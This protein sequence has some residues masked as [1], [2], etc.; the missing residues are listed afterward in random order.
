M[1]DIKSSIKNTAAFND[2]YAAIGKNNPLLSRPHRKYRKIRTEMALAQALVS[3]AG[4]GNNSS[5]CDSLDGV[6]VRQPIVARRGYELLLRR[7][8]AAADTQPSDLLYMFLRYHA[9]CG[10]HNVAIS[11][12]VLHFLTK[13]C[14]LDEIV[15]MIEQLRVYVCSD[16][17]LNPVVAF[18]VKSGV[19]DVSSYLI[20]TYAENCD[21]YSS[22][23]Q[24]VVVNML[25]HL[26]LVFT[27]YGASGPPQFPRGAFVRSVLKAMDT[28]HRR[29]AKANIAFNSYES[30]RL[31]DLLAM[32]ESM[33]WVEPYEVLRGS[34]VL[35][36]RG[37][38]DFGYYTDDVCK[39]MGTAPYDEINEFSRQIADVS[40]ELQRLH[41]GRNLLF[42]KSMWA[43]WDQAAPSDLSPSVSM[44]DDHAM[45]R[46]IAT[47]A[48]SNGYGHGAMEAVGNA[49]NDAVMA[50][51]ESRLDEAEPDDHAEEDDESEDDAEDDSEDSESTD[52][53]DDEDYDEEGDEENNDLIISFDD[54]GR[55]VFNNDDQKV[56]RRMTGWKR[57]Y[58]Q[59]NA[60][61][62]KHTLMA[63]MGFLGMSMWTDIP[64]EF[65][66]ND[67][68]TELQTSHPDVFL[69]HEDASI[70]AQLVDGNVPTLSNDDDLEPPSNNALPSPGDEWRGGPGGTTVEAESGRADRPAFAVDKIADD[71]DV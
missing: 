27:E 67:V 23:S 36:W 14:A 57:N 66:V 54:N 56:D 47:G 24:A 4:V 42:A 3:V 64:V 63:R 16:Q 60:L 1:L 32:C 51:F 22:S 13:R 21:I 37:D 61:K 34:N 20:M 9:R 46:N 41:P 26:F 71:K 15:Q 12:R 30:A 33:G 39:T 25:R 55:M 68:T 58:T 43:E 11:E 7:Q 6:D 45:I 10:S 62:K 5:V 50:A 48:G 52:E 65:P 8:A 18:L 38:A 35:T 70:T 53:S 17:L 40:R 2:C 44:F 29:L 31:T 19:H 49:F 69:Y 28:Y 59:E